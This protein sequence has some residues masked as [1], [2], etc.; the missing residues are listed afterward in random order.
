M[1]A[2]LESAIKKLNN[3]AI[4]GNNNKIY[5]FQIEQS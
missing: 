1:M 4:L 3:L 5:R 2:S